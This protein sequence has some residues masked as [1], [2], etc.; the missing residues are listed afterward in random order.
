MS[1]FDFLNRFW[2]ECFKEPFSVSEVALY[3]YLVNE[4]NRQRWEMPIRCNTQTMSFHLKTSRQT[5]IN[6]RA[7][8]EKRKMIAFENGLSNGVPAKYF[9]L[10]TFGPS[11]LTDGLT[12]E[13]TVSLTDEFTQ[14]KKK[15]KKNTFRYDDKRKNDSKCRRTKVEVSGD[16]DYEAPF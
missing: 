8:L 1:I 12:K 11:D 9:L 7:V 10:P 2:Q 6:A 16:A 13:L 15:N 3:F 14:N 5:I 4:A